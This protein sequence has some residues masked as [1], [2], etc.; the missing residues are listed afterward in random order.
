MQEETHIPSSHITRVIAAFGAFCGM[1]IVLG[2]RFY[3]NGA[4]GFGPLVF[5]LI[6]SALFAVIVWYL[7]IILSAIFAPYNPE[8]D[9][10]ES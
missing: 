3:E 6:I 2:I 7:D 4:E 5:C 1:T 10:D 9:E 8:D